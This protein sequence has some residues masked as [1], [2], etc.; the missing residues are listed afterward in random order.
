MNLRSAIV[1]L[2]LRHYTSIAPNPATQEQFIAYSRLSEGDEAILFL[3]ILASIQPDQ[4][5]TVSYSL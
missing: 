1:K 3:I 2:S 4:F 5:F